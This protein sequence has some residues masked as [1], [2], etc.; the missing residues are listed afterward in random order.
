MN[1]LEGKILETFQW[2]LLNIFLNFLFSKN[3]TQ[4]TPFQLFLT[5]PPKW[6]KSKSFQGLNSLLWTLVKI[7]E[8]NAPT[9]NPQW[10]LPKYPNILGIWKITA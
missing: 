1:F 4:K 8:N 2:E 5:C 7:P 10:L 6:N 9:D 3:F